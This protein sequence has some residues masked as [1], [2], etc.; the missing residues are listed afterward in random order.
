MTLDTNF[1]SFLD[2]VGRDGRGRVFA[3]LEPHADHPPFAT[4]HQGD[5]RREIVV[6]HSN[7]VLGMGHHPN[8]INAMIETALRVGL[9]GTR[10]ISSGGR[11]VATLEAELAGL[12]RKEAAL[13]F[14]SGH[15]VH[16]PA[17]GAIGQLLPE[18]LFLSDEKNDRSIAAG[19][20]AGGAEARIFRHNDHGDL[21]RL[22]AATDCRRPKIVVFASLNQVDGDIAPIGRI[23]DLA[24]RYGALTYLDEGPAVGLYGLHGAGIAERGGAMDRIDIIAGSLA[25][26]FG[27]AGG[28]IAAHAAVCEAVRCTAPAFDGTAALPPPVAAAATQSIRHLKDS[29]AERVAHR[30][31]VDK[32]RKALRAAGIPLL[33]SRS[34]IIA[35][36][37][38]DR[39]RCREA[40][41][42]LLD[43]Y[44]IYLKPIGYPTVAKGS[45]RLC[46]TPTPFHNDRLIARLADALREVWQALDLPRLTDTAPIPIFRHM[47]PAA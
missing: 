30:M 10:D 36:P 7:D 37:I 5:I 27:V 15:S 14:G 41:I 3:D 4:W 31:R 47:R 22:L 21:E 17:L 16:E 12:H 19:I 6:W 32:S 23:C 1:C 11:A 39:A 38:N 40:A 9:G 13:V 20:N 44:G 25:Q 26:G 8:V 33:P 42:M 34:H 18:C 2:D 28:Y 35:V 29:V 45:E 24:A 43:R 46:I